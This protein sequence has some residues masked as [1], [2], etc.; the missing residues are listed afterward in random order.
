[1]QSRIDDSL[2]VLADVTNTWSELDEPP[3]KVEIQQSIKQIE[4]TIAAMKE[5]IKSLA[6]LQKMR[7]TTEMNHLQQEAQRLREKEIHINDLLQPYQEQIIELV[8][9]VEQ[10]VGE[11][12]ATRNE[13]DAAEDSSISQ[14]MLDSAQERVAAM[15]NEVAGLRDKLQRTSQEAKEKLQQEKP[16]GSGSGTSHK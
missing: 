15:Q 4:N 1:M 7:K 14:D 13:I 5:E 8:D 16:A 10:K 11:F 2:S 3:E 9:A 12:T 6:A